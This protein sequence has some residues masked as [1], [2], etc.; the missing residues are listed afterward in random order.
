MYQSPVMPSSKVWCDA[1]I[2]DDIDAVEEILSALDTDDLWKLL[3]GNIDLDECIAMLKARHKEEIFGSCPGNAWSLAVAS[4]ALGVI[5]ML[6]RDYNINV[7]QIDH[8]G[9]NAIH[10][11]IRA[12]HRRPQM[13]EHLAKTYSVLCNL[14]PLEDTGKLL[15]TENE[16]GLRPLE[17][18]VLLATFQI[19]NVIFSTKGEERDKCGS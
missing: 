13:E 6:V 14:L 18:S 15:N 8:R 19:L 5:K 3:H 4:G 12:A 10:A 1:I 17:F 2:R 16:D 9:D 11:M 7:H